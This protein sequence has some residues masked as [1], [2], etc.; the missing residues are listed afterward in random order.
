[1]TANFYR[2]AR[3][4][5]KTLLSLSI[6]AFPIDPLMILS[7]C[8][9]T[10]VHTYREIMGMCG[11]TNRIAF[12]L[13]FMEGKE[14]ITIQ[15]N[16]GNRI[17]YE[18]FYDDLIYSLR[19]RFTLAH[20]LGHVILKH[21]MEEAFEELEADYYAAQLLVPHPIV[22]A[23]NNAGVQINPE[24]ISSTFEVSKAAARMAMMPP[25]HSRNDELYAQLQH[26]FETFIN[27]QAMSIAI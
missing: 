10:A 22:E 23:L 15:R 14:A 12:R 2:A 24:F 4:A 17:G 21:H 20:E 3:M 18:L 27:E 5:Y 26:Q 25:K 1:M 6:A 16:F 13:D 11:K 9:N 19:R 8:N 7:Y